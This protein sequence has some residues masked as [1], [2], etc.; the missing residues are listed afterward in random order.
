MKA[1]VEQHRNSHRADSARNRGDGSCFLADFI[2]LDITAQ[3]AV[4]VTVHCNIDHDS[5]IFH[6]IRCDQSGLSGC[7]NQNIR[8]FADLLQIARARMT[9]RN[10]C[11]PAEQKKRQRLSDDLM[12]PAGV[13]GTNPASP[14][15][16]R[17]MLTA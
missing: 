8:L 3:F 17:P 2:E 5:L 12:I 16:R 4:F 10:R 6:M 7:G 14:V 11:I 15:I 1:I 9:D 13:H